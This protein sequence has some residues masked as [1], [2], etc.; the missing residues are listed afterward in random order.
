MGLG[1]TVFRRASRDTMMRR[2]KSAVMRVAMRLSKGVGM[3]MGMSTG[4]DGLD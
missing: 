3:G 2:P 4:M 1:R